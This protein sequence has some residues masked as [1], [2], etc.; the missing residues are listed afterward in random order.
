MTDTTRAQHNPN[1]KHGQI[2]VPIT[3]IRHIDFVLNR[4]YRM[5][6]HITLMGL[7]ARGIDPTHIHCVCEED[8]SCCAIEHLHLSH[9]RIFNQLQRDGVPVTL[10]HA[11]G[12]PC[13]HNVEGV[14]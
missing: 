11:D 10:V 1:R 4:A 12:T 7:V 13:E 8:G 9:V 14:A 6:T 5:K 3:W 2:P